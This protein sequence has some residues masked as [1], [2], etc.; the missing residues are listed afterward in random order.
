M[1]YAKI[2]ELIER[3]PNLEA[4]DVSVRAEILLTDASAI[5]QMEGG[6]KPEDLSEVEVAVYRS[7]CCDMVNS[8]LTQ[9]ES[10]DVSQIST[11]AGSFTESF[12]FRSQ[13]GVLR[14]TIPQRKLLGLS[15]MKIGSIKP[16]REGKDD[17]R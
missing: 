14:M 16:A 4:A 7:V 12:S 11:T 9:P 10:G 6:K 15:S 1:N 5:I 3:Y 8:V 17:E 2:D 13:P